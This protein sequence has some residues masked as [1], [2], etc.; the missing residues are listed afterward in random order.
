MSKVEKI[1]PSGIF[2]TY[3]FKAIPLAFDESMSYYEMLCAILDRL[4]NDE[5]VINNNADL[6]AELESYVKHYFDNLDVQ[7]EINNKLDEMVLDGTMAEIINEEIF[8]ELNDKIDNI[9][10]STLLHVTDTLPLEL[11]DNNQYEEI[12]SEDEINITEIPK[13]NYEIT[14]ENY[15]NENNN[16]NND[17]IKV[18]TWNIE[19][20]N[21]P[22]NI[23]ING[24]EKQ[25]KIKNILNKMGASIIGLNETFNGYLYP[26][27]KI[28]TT[29]FLKNAYFGKT[30][31]GITNLYYGNTTVSEKTSSSTTVTNFNNVGSDN[32]KRCVI[33]NVYIVNNKIVSHYNLHFTYDTSTLQ[34]QINEMFSLI[35]NDSNPYKIISGDFNFDLTNSD[36]YLNAFLNAGYKLVNGGNYYTYPS[37]NKGID[38]IMVSNNIDIISSG[39]LTTDETENVSDHLPIYATLKL[40]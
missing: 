23:G 31:T 29:K 20:E 16:E 28:Y 15:I 12:I 1:Q 14:K 4:K 13:S 6:L 34:S 3:I 22:Y 19:N 40:N 5:E 10:E 24:L 7:E 33:K 17:M 35:S 32:E 8:N 39:M 37:S 21:V 36:T 38:E 30:A 2:T 11:E 27:N 25:N 26:A 18:A 9:S